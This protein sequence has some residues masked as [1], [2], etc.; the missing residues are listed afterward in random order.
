VLLVTAGTLN[1]MLCTWLYG[2]AAG[3]QL[4][5][6][7][8]VTIAIL[9]FHRAERAVMA[10]LLLLPVAAYFMLGHYGMPPFQ[11][12]WSLLGLNVGSVGILTAFLAW[13]FT[14]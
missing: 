13:V 12:G 10:A 5:L 8:C 7:P 2:E 4:F 11:H 9:L 1:T 3:E 6:L 14:E